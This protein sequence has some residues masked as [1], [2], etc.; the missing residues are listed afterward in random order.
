MRKSITISKDINEE[1]REYCRANGISHSQLIE[2]SVMMFLTLY[3]SSQKIANI[4]ESD[5]KQTKQ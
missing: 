2:K 3:K 1:I 5:N 4:I